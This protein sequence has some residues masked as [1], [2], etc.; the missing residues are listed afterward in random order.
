[1]QNSSFAG[2]HRGLLLTLFLLGL[3]TA[4]VAVPSLFRAEVAVKGEGLFIRTT[5][6]N[7]SIPNFDIR[8]EKGD[9]TTPFLASARASVGKD[10]SAVA[11]VRDSFVDGENALRSRLPQVKFEYNDTLRRPEVITPDVW[12]AQIEFLSAPSSVKR[13]EILRSF[14]HENNSLVGVN[15]AQANALRVAADYTNPNGNMSFAH[16]EQVINGV[17]VFGGEIK[18]GFTKEGRIIRVI[19]NLA[20]G[21][22]YEGLNADFG[23]PIDSVRAAYRYINAEPKEVDATVNEAA[24]NDLRTVFGS[25]DWATTAEKMYFPTEPGVA[26]PSWRVLIWQPVNAYYVIV[27]AHTGTMLWRK[28]VTEDQT[29][30][31]TYQIY[32]NTNA[33]VGAHDSPAPLSPGPI[34]P[35]MGTQGALLTRSTHTLIGNEAP[36]AFNNNGWIT[37]GANTTDGNNLEAG[38]DRDGTNGVDA[39]QT[40]NPNR[41]FD[42]TWNPPP[43]SPAPGDE[44][45]TA[46]AQRGS[47]IQMFYVMNRYHDELYRLGFT[48]QARNF[49]ASNFGR[50]GVEN[51]RISAEGQDSSGTNNA[52]FSIV[53]DGA[54]GRMQMYLWT[55]PT[56]DYDGTGDAEV[57]IHEVTHGTS[58]RLHGNSTGLSTNMARGMGEGWGDFFGYSMLAEPTDAING[59]YTTG[60]Y[61]TYLLGGMTTNYYHGIRRFPRAPITLTGGPARPGCNNQPCPHNPFTF[62]HLNSNCDTTLGTTASAV[63]S[64]FPRNPSVATSGSCDQ[65]HNAGEV[66][67]SALWEVRNRM[68]TRLGFTAGTA[69]VLQ[70]VLDGMKLAPVGPTFLQERDAIITAAAALPVAPEAAA[71]VVDVR[72]GFRVRGMGFSASIQSASPASVTE[73]FDVPNAVLTDPF[74]VSDPGPGGDGDT[75][76]E[77]GETVVLSVPVTNNSGAPV[78]GVMVTLTGG[79]T[80]NYGDLA[81]GQTVTRTFTYVIPIA[82][83]CGSLHTV[84]FSLTSNVGT[85]TG[86]TRQFL[87]GKFAGS[88]NTTSI[89]IPDSGPGSPYPSPVTVSG[90]A[91]TAAVRVRLFGLTHTFP[92][93][94]DFLL[95]GPGGQKMVIMSDVGSSAGVTNAD[96]ILEDAAAANMPT[97][98]TSVAGTWR[99]TNSGTTDTFPAP[100]PAAPYEHPAPGGTATFASVFGT[101][102]TNMNG[103]WNLYLVD[104]AG[105]DLGALNG[106][107]AISFSTPDYEC[108]FNPSVV[109]SRADF[110]GDGRTDL[111]VFRP[112]EGNWYLNRSTAG[113]QVLKWGVSGDTLVPGDYDGDGTTDTA[114]FRPNADSTQPDFYILNSTGFT[115]TGSSWGIAGDLPVIADYDG[116]QKSDVAVFRPSNNTW[117]ILKSGGGATFTV[118]GQ[119]GDVP[120]AG[121]FDNHAAADLVVYRN[122]FWIGQLSAGGTMNTALGTAGDIIVPADYSNDNIDDIAVFRPSTGQ[123]LVINSQGGGVNTTSF[124]TAGDIPVPGD[125]D[126]DG[127]DDFAIYRNGTWW[128]NRSTSGLLVQAFGLSTDTAVPRRYLP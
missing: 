86:I 93:D 77:P 38:I 85:N 6:S 126:G 112:S 63:S 42:S 15:D 20:P 79:G 103:T 92:G 99:P 94:L 34:D 13:S 23:N 10:A 9:E 88:R 119:P 123:W 57:I 61:A 113:F 95:V 72:D 64:A 55:G 107:W 128:V 22:N 118:F 67:S 21:L 25:G 14:I 59:V 108:T 40:G 58:N 36:F 83:P 73:A 53:A 76:P 24:S 29:Q 97:T 124:G 32:R 62:K 78:T 2:T 96:I 19:N 8:T 127:R 91:G 98:A 43:G 17:P 101:N 33:F 74:T 4:L 109:R 3:V 110:D 49:Q 121:N 16:L 81:N 5:S 12:K 120:V 90:I 82:A 48:E 66:W 60:G 18:A 39:P 46:Q 7:P 104:D 28:N 52:N 106:G 51:D 122:G 70:V 54:R 27:D 102:G 47:V 69:R 87:L 56:P 31:A 41:T 125:Y 111:S 115:V 35:T 71:D 80:Q 105:G 84:T 30:T 68:V 44:P 37:D 1:M 26:V 65:V 50:G 11:D 114:V 75:F 116:D 89:S 45:L 117:Y 100:A